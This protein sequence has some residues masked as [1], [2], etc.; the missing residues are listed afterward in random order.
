M[1]LD[2]R[3]NLPNEI[4]LSQHAKPMTHQEARVFFGR[5]L[6]EAG[7]EGAVELQTLSGYFDKSLAGSRKPLAVKTE[8]GVFVMKSY[9]CS[10]D[11]FE[12]QVLQNLNGFHSPKPVF[13]GNHFI[14][15]E[16]LQYRQ[17]LLDVFKAD[18]EEAM[19]IGAET[20]AS[21]ASRRITFYTDHNWL[22]DFVLSGI[23]WKCL[24]FGHSRPFCEK[25]ENQALDSATV[26]V[27][28]HGDLFYLKDCGVAPFLKPYPQSP[29]YEEHKRVL[30]HLATLKGDILTRINV[31][32]SIRQA[33]FG[34]RDLLL[35]FAGEERLN[36][37]FD[38]MNDVAPSYI[39]NFV[40]KFNST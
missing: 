25:G 38:I 31:Y 29:H 33:L 14:I 30:N 1:K 24:D 26:T 4:R 37:A 40:N 27:K 2:L 21:L 5:N 34:I 3:L 12:K 16:L 7:I 13:L 36:V 6:E 11:K 23:E 22:N 15:D 35:I 18:Q 32:D 28:K 19:R 17:T 20:R 8:K 39:T 9:A 10:E